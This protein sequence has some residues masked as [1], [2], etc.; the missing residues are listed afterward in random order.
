[1]STETHPIGHGAGALSRRRVPAET[2][3]RRRRSAAA[4]TLLAGRV[5]RALTRPAWL[6]AAGVAR[7]AWLPSLAQAV[8]PA[9]IVVTGLVVLLVDGH[10]VSW[11]AG[12]LAGAAA[13]LWLLRGRLAQ[14]P[15][16]SVR[17]EDR[18][19][20]VLEPLGE[21][22][23]RFLHDI[24]GPDGPYHHIAVGRGGVILLQSL[25]PDGAVS[26]R[27][28]EPILERQDDP[29]NAPRLER[30]RPRVLL[31]AAAV[32]EAV[33]RLTG[34]RVWVQAVVVFWSDFPAGCVATGRC[35]FIHG[36]RLADWLARRPHQLDEGEVES[37]FAD[38]AVLEHAAE[39]ALPVAV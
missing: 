18:T 10:D 35:V 3:A 11:L 31:D 5:P 17:A 7:P 36:S 1:M 38:V 21:S 6:G 34:R 20:A 19:E 23:W 16:D 27:S 39:L 37:V 26:I 22:G 13:V 24:P 29:F 33:H 12:L 9:A 28:G 4:R 8:I 2:P 30:I 25:S 15:T 32:R 14:S